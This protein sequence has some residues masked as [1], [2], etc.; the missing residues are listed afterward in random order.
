MIR[1]AV[2]LACI[3]LLVLRLAFVEL[4]AVH[5]NTMAPAVLDGDVL[6]VM[7]QTKP[8]LGDVVLVDIGGQTVVRRVI[9]LAGHRIGSLAGVLTRDELPVATHV[10]GTFAWREVSEEQEA[11]QHRQHHFVEALTEDRLHRMLGDH[12][13]AAKPWMLELPEVEVP[14]GALFVLCD[15]RR[16]CPLDERSGV[17]PTTAITG[18][19]HSLLWYGDARVE[20]VA[21]RPFYGAFKPLASGPAL[22]GRPGQK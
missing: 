13:G 4:V 22:D 2:V 1:V 3:A 14:P 6:L 5:G 11:P 8:T 16:Q 9:G 17:V 7:A 15:N 19:V 12:V 10:A 21:H 20:P 18:V